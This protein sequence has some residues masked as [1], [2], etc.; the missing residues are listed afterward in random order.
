MMGKIKLDISL[1]N[2]WKSW[3]SFSR[4]KR[5]T[6]EFE[7][8]QYNLEENLYD[9]QQDIENGTYRHGGYRSFFVSENKRR[10]IQ[11]ASIRDRIAH[12]LIYNYL[13]NIYDK[14]FIY[15]VW[16]CRIGKG[17]E[18]A[19]LR[20]EAFVS[21][22]N[23]AY[24]WRGDIKKY[25]DNIDRQKLTQIIKRKIND[26]KA[27]RLLSEIIN[28]K[29]DLAKKG[30]PIGNLTSQIFGNIYLNEFDRYLKHILKIKF[31]MRYGDD[32]IIILRDRE[33]LRKVCDLAHEFLKNELGL[34]INSKNEYV[35]KVNRGI[36]FLGMKIYP[37]SKTL[38]R[39]N[40]VRLK[41]NLSL[42]N[43]SSYFGLLLLEGNKQRKNELFWQLDNILDNS[44]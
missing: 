14:T 30:I 37:Y 43:F 33:K 17:L 29:D 40:I 23:N 4:G 15:D 13:V 35:Y 26:N 11:V 22:N 7:K 38:T 19:I 2:I 42:T 5:K 9:L 34:T 24:V 3:Y 1:S 10:K 36:H 28:G 32:F 44:Y 12:R 25:F 27:T 18:K 39:R 8:F 21:K 20:S 41:Q 31:Y 16:S 6:L